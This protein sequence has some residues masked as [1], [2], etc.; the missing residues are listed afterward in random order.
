MQ[1]I[2]EDL[3]IEAIGEGWFY[4]HLWSK[5]SKLPWLKDRDM[6]PDQEVLGLAVR[7]GFTFAYIFD[8]LSKKELQVVAN[9]LG[10]EVSYGRNLLRD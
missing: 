4:D 1:Y 9:Y 7:S 5:L 2:T 8:Q 6:P 10:L 3:L